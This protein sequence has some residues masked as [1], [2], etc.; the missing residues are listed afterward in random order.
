MPTCSAVVAYILFSK[1]VECRV[2]VLYSANSLASQVCSVRPATQTSS[3]PR[4]LSSR[5][6]LP[7]TL[8]RKRSSSSLSAMDSKHSSAPDTQLTTVELDE[9][10]PVIA[11]AQQPNAPYAITAR[12]APPDEW[13]ASVCDCYVDGQRACNYVCCC[14]PCV[15]ADNAKLVGCNGCCAGFAYCLL[16][17]QCY[18]PLLTLLPGL[19]C[20]CCVHMPIRRRLRARYGIKESYF[21]EDFLCTTFC[22]PCALCQEVRLLYPTLLSLGRFANSLTHL[23]CFAVDARGSHPRRAEP[24]GRELHLSLQGLAIRAE[25]ASLLRL[26]RRIALIIINCVIVFRSVKIF[27]LNLFFN[28]YRV[29][30][31][32]GLG[33]HTTSNITLL[34]TSSMYVKEVHVTC[35]MCLIQER[36]Y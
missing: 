5:S 25:G 9:V 30:L 33:T 15:I 6:R 36:T 12:A 22:A 35:Y 7:Q 1:S 3:S 26:S 17:A 16:F 14:A 21:G 18:F 34:S 20:S 27:L 31:V 4:P 29:V 19:P 11:V 32:I 10:Q 13:H 2:V 28:S 24:Q 8:E 23:A